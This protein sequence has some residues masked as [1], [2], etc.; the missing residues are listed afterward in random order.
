MGRNHRSLPF[1]DNVY[2]G[3]KIELIGF[4]PSNQNALYVLCL[5]YSDNEILTIRGRPAICTLIGWFKSFCLNT[6]L[7][8]SVK[9]KSAKI[10]MFVQ[11]GFKSTL[12]MVGLNNLHLHQRVKIEEQN[13]LLKICLRFYANFINIYLE[14]LRT[15][16]F[17]NK[18]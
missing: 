13:F 6:S 7:F 11:G 15:H 17:K 4:S 9:R 12:L 8:V 5:F 3:P 2:C 10:A 18:T 1:L 16:F 14:L